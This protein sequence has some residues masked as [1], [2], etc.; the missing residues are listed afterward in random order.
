MIKNIHKKSK[1]DIESIRNEVLDDLS[2]ISS[3]LQDSLDL[4]WRLIEQD[5]LFGQTEDFYKASEKITHSE[6][7][8]F[9][10]EIF[11][12][13]QERVTV[14]IFPGELT[15]AENDFKLETALALGQVEYHSKSLVEMLMFRDSSVMQGQN[16]FQSL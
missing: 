11:E 10:V 3:S 16:L 5:L 2:G 14:E 6:L 8:E 1:D 15:E 4:Q 12:S 13:M 7:T 9:A